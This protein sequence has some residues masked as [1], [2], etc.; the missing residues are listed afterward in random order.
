MKTLHK[1]LSAILFALLA[2][3][4]FA[5]CSSDSDDGSITAGYLANGATWTA[6]IADTSCGTFVFKFDRTVAVDIDLSG[7]EASE[8]AKELNITTSTT[9]YST[10]MATLKNFTYSGTGYYYIQDSEV[11][12]LIDDSIDVGS[13]ELEGLMIGLTYSSG[14]LVG[15]IDVEL[16]ISIPIPIPISIPITLTK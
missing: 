13:M 14:V 16:P 6:S 15:P 8:L 3:T 5:A 7:L 2:V 11:V 12:I 4:F 9:G 10:I 1:T